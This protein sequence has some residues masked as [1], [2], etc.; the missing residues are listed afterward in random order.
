MKTYD[1]TSKIKAYLITVF[2]LRFMFY[3]ILKSDLFLQLK[4]IFTEKEHII[5]AAEYKIY[6]KEDTLRNTK[7]RT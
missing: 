5:D 7:H 4:Y 2:A 3:V 1:I 6:Y